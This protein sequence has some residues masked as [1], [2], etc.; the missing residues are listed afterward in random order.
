[1][2]QPVREQ[3]G[4]QKDIVLVGRGKLFELWGKENWDKGRAQ[5]AVIGG[6]ND[7]TRAALGV[8]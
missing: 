6:K 4:I 2:P 1:L 8:L 7:D 5:L 3:V